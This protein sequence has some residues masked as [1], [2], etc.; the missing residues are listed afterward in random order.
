M[1]RPSGRG[2]GRLS[3]TPEQKRLFARVVGFGVGAFV[4][5]YVFTTLLV[6]PGFGRQAIVTVPDLRGKTFAAARRAADAEDLQVERGVSLAHPTV[7]AGAVLA[8]SPLPGQETTRGALIRLTLSAGRERRPVPAV[9][10]LTAQL[11]Q[12]LLVRTGFG[13]RVR[14]LVSERAEGRVLGTEPAAGASL[15]VGSVVELRVSAGPPEVVV[16]IV[17]V[18]DLSDLTESEARA[19]LRSA[20]LRLGGVEYDPQSS[21][22]LGGVGGQRPAAGDSVRAGTAV[23]IVLSGSPP[24]PAAEPDTPPDTTAAPPPAPPAR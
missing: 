9:G 7:P 18:P 12:D 3:F 8:Q 1:S 13:V 21:T 14:R 5:G 6:F 24:P 2:T 15:P 22:V 10:D 23:S 16:P 19:A 11:A 17:A 20:G 4:L